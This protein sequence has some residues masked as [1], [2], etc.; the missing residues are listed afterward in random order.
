[1]GSSTYGCTA[2]LLLLPSTPC[3]VLLPPTT[4][5]VHPCWGPPTPQLLMSIPHAQDGGKDHSPSPPGPTSCPG[6]R[7]LIPSALP[8]TGGCRNVIPVGTKG[9]CASGAGWRGAMAQHP[10]LGQGELQPKASVWEAAATSLAWP[11][12]SWPGSAVS[13]M[14]PGRKT[15]S[16][17]PHLW[18]HQQ[19][20]GSIL[21]P[22]AQGAAP[23]L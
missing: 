17:P 12:S 2:P 1:M 10:E 23:M 15:P 19:R 11:H 5:A 22:P 21:H 8:R 14:L 20:G 16:H 6:S 18:F 4:R 3:P 7:A 9:L 13:P